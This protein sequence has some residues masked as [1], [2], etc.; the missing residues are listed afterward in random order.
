MIVS[1]YPPFLQ[2]LLDSCPNAG[3]GVHAWLFKVARYLHRYHSADEICPILE[4]RV[5]GCGRTVAPHE[6]VD[7]VR[8][9]ALC[10][11]QSSGRTASERRAEWIASP[12][13]R[14]V[15]VFDP[16]LAIQTA[17]RVPIDITPEWLKAHSPV[18]VNCPTGKFLTLLFGSHE[19]ALI[20]SRYKS[21]GYLWPSE[22]SIERFSQIRW[23]DGAWFL[24]NPIDGQ[25]H[26]N[27]RMLKESRR[28]E[29]SITSFRFAVLECDQKPKE[30]WLPVWLKILV[31]L[32]LEIVSITDSAGKSAHALVRVS[33]SSKAAWDAIKRSILRPLVALGVDDGALT[34]VRL[35]RLPGCYRGDHVQELLYLSPCADGTPIFEQK[36]AS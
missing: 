31:Q 24:C 9:S 32:P 10:A 34:A 36:G 35:S 18:P 17:S 21:Q 5:A 7:A 33:A 30:K 19:K 4:A 2:D 6:I 16:E 28:S 8:N 27:P 26:W 29:E 13:M 22:V 14:R 15:P 25:S 11:W 3:E 12:T 23:H 1:N 20:F